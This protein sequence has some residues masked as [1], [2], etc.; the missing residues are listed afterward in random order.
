TCCFN[1]MANSV[2]LRVLRE[3][4][5]NHPHLTDLAKSPV[6]FTLKVNGRSDIGS[7]MGFSGKQCYNFTMKTWLVLFLGARVINNGREAALLE[8]PHKLFVQFDVRRVLDH[9]VAHV[10]LMRGNIYDN[11][12][13]CA[14]NKDHAFTLVSRVGDGGGSASKLP[15]LRR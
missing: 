3:E 6:Y 7:L 11:G 14:Q 4:D 9:S 13:L 2:Q 1:P 15:A 5:K 12:K 10:Y 8:G